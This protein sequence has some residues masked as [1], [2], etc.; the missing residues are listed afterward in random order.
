M[1]IINLPGGYELDDDPARVNVRAAH[2]YLGGE[3]YWA[4]GR[5]FEVTAEVIAA[6]DRVVGC[7]A[8]DGAMVG[9]A[10]A[11]SDG[12]TFAYLGDV[13]VL[14]AHR[15]RGLGKAVVRE[16]IEGAPFWHVRWMLG[17]LDA[18]ALYEQFGFGAPTDRVMERRRRD[19]E[20]GEPQ[21]MGAAG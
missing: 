18:H 5:A 19:P 1:G 7:Y 16:I 13:Y 11:H 20:T 9:F 10:R 21:E 6:A 17:T 8:P 4:K 3:S 14:E 15:G 2:A 12:H